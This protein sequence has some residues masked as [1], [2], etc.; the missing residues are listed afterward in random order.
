MFV[1]TIK[2]LFVFGDS[3]TYFKNIFSTIDQLG[4]ALGGGNSDVTISARIGYFSNRGQSKLQ[5]WWRMMEK[6]INFTFEPLDGLGHCLQSYNN[7]NES[8]H[9]EGND[10]GRAFIGI[11]F[12]SYVPLSPY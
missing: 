4:N 5:L 2:T 9:E 8:K 6:V 11:A 12:L 7:D 10:I 1:L 3:L